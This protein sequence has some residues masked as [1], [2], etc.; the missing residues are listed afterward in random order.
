[1][2]F[3]KKN[4]KLKKAFKTFTY[5]INYIFLIVYQFFFIL[6]DLSLVLSTKM[7]KIFFY[8]Y[9]HQTMFYK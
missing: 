8:I 7:K 2:V 1:M 5:I 6:S 3:F 4:G 9:K